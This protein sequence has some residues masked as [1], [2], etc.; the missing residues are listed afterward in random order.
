MA[1]AIGELASVLGEL[2]RHWWVVAL[3]GLAAIV[4]GILAFVWP[5]LT[6]TVLVLLFGAYAIVDGVLALYAALRSGGKQV[7]VSLLEGVVGIAAGLVAF[8]LP[9]LTALALLFVIAAWAIVTGVLEVI[10]AVRLREVIEHEWMMIFSGA[11]SVIF[12]ILLVAQPG[13]G[14][15]A[16]VWL[17]GTYAV[18]FGV[19]LVVL[20]WRLRSVFEDMHSLRSSLRETT[21]A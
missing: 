6:L 10:A 5:G 19:S 7:W 14:A 3:R 17:I 1:S 21:P 18:I 20:A 2:P 4:F 15:L 16:V 12:G 13:A 8:F 9:G 11:L